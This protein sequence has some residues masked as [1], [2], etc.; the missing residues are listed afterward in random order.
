M[1]IFSVLWEDA[2]ISLELLPVIPIFHEVPLEEITLKP[3]F[4]TSFCNMPCRLS[5]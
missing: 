5:Y 1:V 2:L 3:T 4:R